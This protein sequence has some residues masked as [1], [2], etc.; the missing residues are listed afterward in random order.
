MQR[1]TPTQ[2]QEVE[3]ELHRLYGIP[4][5][6][7]AHLT[8]YGVDRP[9]VFAATVD[10]DPQ[11]LKLPLERVGTYFATRDDRGLRLSMDGAA[12]VADHADDDVVL[13]LTEAEARRWLAGK[14]LPRPPGL[15]RPFV[16]LRRGEDVLGCG[17]VLH[18][19]IHNRVRKSRRVPLDTGEG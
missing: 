16:L 6:A 18:D 14:A 5:E 17:L 7:V 10:L 13:E 15:H 12:L 1:L 4:P 19:S 9:K 2:R 11:E 3:D 8:L